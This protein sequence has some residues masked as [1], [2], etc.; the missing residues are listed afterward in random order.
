MTTTTPTH[1]DL[2][3]ARQLSGLLGCAT[4]A[5]AAALARIP[6]HAG[7]KLTAVY[8]LVSYLPSYRIR[9]MG[10]RFARADIDHHIAAGRRV[11]A[12]AP[13][14]PTPGPPLASAPPDEDEEIMPGMTRRQ[15]HAKARIGRR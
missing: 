14:R 1:A 9:G 10:L 13:S 2:L 7:C 12:P 3:T 6:T 4:C 15:L 11:P 8:R 5:A